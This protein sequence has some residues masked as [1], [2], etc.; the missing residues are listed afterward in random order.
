MIS[1]HTKY[2]NCE[3]DEEW[4]IH[5]GIRYNDECIS[6]HNLIAHKT[7]QTQLKCSI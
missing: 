5:K 4:P 2:S 7:V 6:E 3:Y 1:W